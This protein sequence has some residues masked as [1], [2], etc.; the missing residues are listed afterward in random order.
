MITKRHWYRT[1]GKEFWNCSINQELTLTS[2][3]TLKCLRKCKIDTSHIRRLHSMLE[4]NLSREKSKVYTEVLLKVKAWALH[5]QEKNLSLAKNTNM[6][7]HRIGYG[8][9]SLLM[10]EE[11]KA[12]NLEGMILSKIKGDMKSQYPLS[13]P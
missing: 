1:K 13:R 12:I 3:L 7:I 10:T 2:S 5:Y 8:N 9:K 6:I 11:R 4:R